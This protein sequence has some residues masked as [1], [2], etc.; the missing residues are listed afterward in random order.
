MR[1]FCVTMY[2][3]VEAEDLEGA[4]DVANQ[5]LGDLAQLGDGVRPLGHVEYSDITE[6]EDA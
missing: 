4:Y 5:L 2:V 6:V 3:D 1:T